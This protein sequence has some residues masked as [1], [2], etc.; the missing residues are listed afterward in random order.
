MIREYDL[1]GFWGLWSV[2][3]IVSLDICNLDR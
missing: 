1:R 2:H 3:I